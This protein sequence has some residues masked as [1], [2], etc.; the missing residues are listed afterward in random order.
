MLENA[1]YHGIETRFKGGK[2]SLVIQVKDQKLLIK[3]TNPLPEA[4]VK[5]RKGNKVAQANLRKRIEAVFGDR[6]SLNSYEAESS[7][8]V[9][10][11]IPL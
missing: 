10:V 11:R 5:R 7:F 8:N 4:G 2:I 6:A 1:V 9:I 3:I